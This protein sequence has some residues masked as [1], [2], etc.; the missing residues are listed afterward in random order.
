MVISH[1]IDRLMQM[2]LNFCQMGLI[3]DYLSLNTT[4]KCNEECDKK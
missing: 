4:W 3:P 2:S 1:T